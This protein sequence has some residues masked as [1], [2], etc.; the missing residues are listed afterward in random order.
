MTGG[1]RELRALRPQSPFAGHTPPPAC[2]C[3]ETSRSTLDGGIAFHARMALTEKRSQG[4]PCHGQRCIHIDILR[5]FTG[6][7]ALLRLPQ[8]SLPAFRVVSMVWAWSGCGA[9]S[10]LSAG[11][12]QPKNGSRSYPDPTKAVNGP[13]HRS[14][15]NSSK[16]TQKFLAHPLSL[17]R[18]RAYIR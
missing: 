9:T 3:C 1:P 13:A 14:V 12:R 7:A 8:M 6:I 17:S 5:W 11:N 15:S 2:G 18:Q 16:G 10:T 4:S